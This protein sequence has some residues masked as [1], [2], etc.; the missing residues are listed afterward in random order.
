[1]ADIADIKSSDRTV[2]ALHPGTGTPVGIRLTI[3]SV[4]DE[5]LKSLR[6]KFIDDRQ[7]A[8]ARGKTLKAEQIEEN[9]ITLNTAA[10]TGWEWYNPTGKEGDKGYDPDAMPDF[11]GEVP[12]F[13]K[14][15]VRAVMTEVEWLR[16][17]ITNEFSDTK[18]FF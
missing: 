12:E 6:R 16:F 3:M 4:E 7:Y 5:R 11:H 1:M 10:I 17:F 9:Q 15:N 2:E 14:K 8:E 18:A 13:N